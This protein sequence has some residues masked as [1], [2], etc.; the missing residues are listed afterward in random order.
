MATETKSRRAPRRLV[1]KSPPRR[2]GGV[3]AGLFVGL[4]I[5]A[6]LAAGSAWY[7]TRTS[8]FQTPQQ[9]VAPIGKDPIALPGKPGDRPVASRDF[10]FY[11]ILPR[12]SEDAK[13]AV[14]RVEAPAPAVSTPP[15]VERLYL[16]VGA[17]QNPA[18]A[19]NM[20]ALLA[21]NGVEAV[22]Q[23]AQLDDGRVVHRVR[24]GPFARPEDM[25]SVRARLAS[26]G[27]TGTVVQGNP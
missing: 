16:Q 21:L 24:V 10:D 11:T 4:V 12:G 22:A 3:L 17:F 15:R 9:V 8:P 27:V 20:K 13:T 26:A 23:R 18:E 1:A 14:A 19:D 25:A 2:S 7:F 5:G 6:L